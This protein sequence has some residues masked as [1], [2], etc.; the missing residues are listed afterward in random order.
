MVR[1]FAL[2]LALAGAAAILSG[3]ATLVHG[4][5]ERVQLESRPAGAE[6]IIDDSR[7]V[8]TPAAVKLSRGSSHHLV[9]HKPGYEDAKAELTSGLSGWMLGNLVAG[10]LVGVMI[11]ATN[12]AG[13][14]L[15]SDTVNMTLM[16]SLPPIGAASFAVPV[17]HA[18]GGQSARAADAAHSP[19]ALPAAEPDPPPVDE[20]AVAPAQT[21]PR[22]AAEFYD[23]EAAYKFRDI[24]PAE[25]PENW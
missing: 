13:H 17:A 23:D 15:S 24:A 6:V 12:G 19:A 21:R 10:G 9:F 2:A 14:K 3:C 25:P 16:P 18:S 4:T 20:T 5:T 1:N 7:H 22:T 8:I 11:D